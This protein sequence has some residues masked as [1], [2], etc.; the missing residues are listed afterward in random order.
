MVMCSRATGHVME[1]GRAAR[2]IKMINRAK[3]ISFTPAVTPARLTL[4]CDRLCVD[5]SPPD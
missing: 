5:V 2:A 4:E 1:G 3:G